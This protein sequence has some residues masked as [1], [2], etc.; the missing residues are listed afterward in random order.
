M[1]FPVVCPSR[2]SDNSAFF[3]A[4]CVMDRVVLWISDVAGRSS[5]LVMLCGNSTKPC[6]PKYS[7]AVPVRAAIFDKFQAF[8]LYVHWFR[9]TAR[10]L[11]NGFQP[12][13]ARDR[14]LDHRQ[15]RQPQR[16]NIR[17]GEHP[18]VPK[19]TD[20]DPRPQRTRCCGCGTAHQSGHFIGVILFASARDPHLGTMWHTGKG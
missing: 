3:E 16:F 18:D 5:A 8:G 9:W 1:Q 15:N 12:S 13:D 10:A 2:V 20:H 14:R 11:D 7:Q 17:A 6:C 4:I 19:A